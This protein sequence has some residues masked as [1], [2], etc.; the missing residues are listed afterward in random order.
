MVTVDF[1][2]K[3]GWAAPRLVPTAPLTFAP[4]ASC[5]HYGT[6]CFEGMKLY[7]G[8]DSRL[9][10]FRPIANATRMLGSATRVALPAFNPTELEKLVIKLCAKDGPRWLPRERGEGFLYVRPTLLGSAGA[11]GVQK[12]QEAMLFIILT[13]FPALDDKNHGLRLLAS[14]DDDGCRAWPG[15]FGNAKVG[16]NCTSASH[17]LTYCFC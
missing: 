14:R 4:T 7:R 12:P 15:G 11:L 1:D 6:S 5:L 10:L 2:Y 8:A 16:A 3:N 9:R 17:V 13:M